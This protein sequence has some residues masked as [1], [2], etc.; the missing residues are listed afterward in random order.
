MP[1]SQHA[2]RERWGPAQTGGGTLI[3][4]AAEPGRAALDGP[5]DGNS[6]YA[7]AL[8]R[9]LSA[10]SGLEFGTVMR[11]V[12]EEVYL[13]TQGQQRPWVN[14]TLTRLIYLDGKPPEL[15]PDEGVILSERR[16]LLLTIAS[17]PE[18][19]R[20]QVETAAASAGVPMDALYGLLRALG[21]DTPADAAALDKLLNTEA[22]R[23]KA[24]LAQQKTLET[25]DAELVRLSG[26]AGQALA[27]GALDAHA[28]FWQKAKARYLEISQSLD[29]VEGQLKAR[30]LEGGEVLA[31]AAAALELK[32]DF[33]AAAENYALAFAEVERWDEE[34]A[35]DYRQRE[36]GAWLS[37]GDEKGDA[38]ALDKAL[39]RYR[40]AQA[41]S[42]RD[43]QPLRW[44]QAQ[45]NIG[46]VLL[47]QGRRV[48]GTSMI[49]A[50]IAAYM[51]ALEVRTREAA[52]RDWAKTQNNLAIA[53]IDM[54]ERSGDQAY[55]ARA[56][57]AYRAALSETPREDDPLVWATLMNNLGDALTRLGGEHLEEAVSVH[58]AALAERPRERVPL[59]WAASQE[60]LGS[61]LVNLGKHQSNPALIK[62]AIAA[63]DAALEVG[64]RER[65][66]LQWSGLHYNLGNA[67]GNLADFADADR[68]LA[69]AVFH[70]RQALLEE[71]FERTPEQWGKTQYM[72]GDRLWS[73]GEERSDNALRRQGVE[74]QRESLKLYTR[75]RNAADWAITVY[76][77]GTKYHRLG[78]LER[79]QTDLQEATQLLAQSLEFY[80]RERNAV[81]WADTLAAYADALA[82]LAYQAGDEKKLVEAVDTFTAALGVHTREAAPV[83][84]A[85]TVLQRASALMSLSILRN[86]DGPVRQ[87]RQD[88]AAAAQVLAE[89]GRERQANTA[90]SLLSGFD[91]LIASLPP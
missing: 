75:E 65:V 8:I 73:L 50:A 83:S 16:Q 30:R 68:H 70:Y 52:P 64:T 42:P 10:M 24:L 22:Q 41:L 6:P 57:E 46:N 32:A 39:D 88:V 5:P 80:T 35:W 43:R 61:A 33:P 91:D 78:L 21:R 47:V 72:L 69:E 20:A 27:D 36:A 12:A 63:Y 49:E 58:R 11:M 87:G 86:D 3:G 74:A 23:L 28:A 60:N 71:T 84:W 59:L 37:Q 85:M 2:G 14:E 67:Y 45:N 53:Y 54:A 17:L 29:E 31:N 15:Q 77:L 55:V 76:I 13:K 1:A 89:Q 40:D 9:H 25:Q 66:P 34:K 19:S 7:A 79:N 18:P 90:R 62:E 56:A 26:L 82:N 38:A 48:A 4:F 81:D 44:A 51:D